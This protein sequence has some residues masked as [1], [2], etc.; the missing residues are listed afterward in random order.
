M[1][2][3]GTNSWGELPLEQYRID[4]KGVYRWSFLLSTESM[5]VPPP[6]SG[7]P[8]RVPP[9]PQPQQNPPGE[10]EDTP[11]PAPDDAPPGE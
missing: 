7:L 5:P 1:G 8:R 2:V 4:P 9:Q 6:V 3:G 11:S 10:Q